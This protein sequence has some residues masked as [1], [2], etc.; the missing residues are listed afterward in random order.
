MAKEITEKVVDSPLTQRVLDPSCGSGTFIE[1]AIENILNHSGALSRTATLKKLQDNVVGID[2]HPVAVQLAKATWVMAAAETIRAARAEG[3]GTGAVSAPIYLGDSMQLRYDT[4]TLSASQSI[5][6]ETGETLPGHKNPII[7]SI[8]KELARQQTDIDRLISALATAIDEDRDTEHIADAYDM[9]DTCRQSVKAIATAMQELHAANRNHVWAYYIRNMIRPA[10]I[11]EQKVDRIIGNPPWLTYGQSADIIRTELRE[12]SDQRYQIW[13]G[14]KLAPHQDIA[15]VFYTRC[16]EL[17]AEVG[18]TIGMV[19]PHSALRTGQHLKWRTGSYKQKGGRNAPSIGLNL[20][21]HEP[22]DLDNL[23]PDFFPMPASVVFAEYKGMRHGAA[24]APATVQVWRGDWQHGYV[25]IRRKSEALHHDDGKYKSPYAELSSQGPTIV[26]RRLFFVETVPHTAMI[27]TEDTTNVKPRM[28]KQDNMHYEGQLNQLEGVVSNDNLF[29]VY[30]GECIAPYV[31]LDPLKAVLPV[32]RPTMTMP[33]NHDNCEGNKH[34]ACRLEITEF[35]A[36][37]QR[38]W[39]NAAEM[40]R[41]AHKNQSIKDLYSNLN[42]LNKLTNQLEYLQGA[43]NGDEMVRVAYTSSGKPT[44]AIV[45]DNH[46]IVDYVLF[47]TVC[48]SEDEAY[49]V[50]AVINSDTLA[51]T[52][53]TFMP[54]GLYGARH[55]QKHGW[56][57]PIPRYDVD[58]PLHVR[59]GELAKT[60]EQECTAI[61]AKSDIMSKPAGDTQSREARKMLRHEWQPTSA[62]AQ[63]IEAAVAELLSNPAQAALAEQQMNA[64]KPAK[65]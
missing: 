43:I 61:I 13:A 37:M 47:Q 3:T 62:T 15:T 24:L 64:G 55:F 2:I 65:I 35:H 12:M 27:P 57:L 45:W 39:S 29:D 19:L 23:I 28:G 20:R 48:C 58:D 49:Y 54:K 56:K 34:D 33:L 52:A 40:F 46:A 4:G 7:F 51:A 11:A 1:T 8:P 18:A 41:E 32:Q 5:Q 17:Y 60:A 38:R 31:A 44:A 16:A 26:D 63:D 50:L 53:E 30:L 59:L 9:S 36:T 22:W 14:G 42:H 21:V 25:D 6:L 10:I